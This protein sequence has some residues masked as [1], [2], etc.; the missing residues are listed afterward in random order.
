MVQIRWGTHPELD[1][2]CES[3]LESAI[4]RPVGSSTGASISVT[5]NLER[6]FGMPSRTTGQ[7]DWN[8]SSIARS[9]DLFRGFVMAF[10]LGLLILRDWIWMVSTK[11][12]WSTHRA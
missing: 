7:F 3:V 10:D 1:L 6:L 9:I 8:S 11:R 12:F 5:T 2:T 4:N